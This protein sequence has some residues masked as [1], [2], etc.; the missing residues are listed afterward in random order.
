M[1]LPPGKKPLREIEQQ[2]DPASRIIDLT[3]LIDFALASLPRSGNEDRAQ[4]PSERIKRNAGLFTSL[5]DMMF[6]IGVRND[7]VHATNSNRKSPGQGEIKRAA[8]ILRRGLL[9][10]LPAI[11]P[12]VASAI[13]RGSHVDPE[14]EKKPKVEKP[15]GPRPATATPTRSGLD[16]TTLVL[17]VSCILALIVL[18]PLIKRALHGSESAAEPLRREARANR[19][20]FESLGKL[21]AFDTLFKEL[22]A[23]VNSGEHFW[24]EYE[25]RAAGERFRKAL[26]VVARLQDLERQRD[27]ATTIRFEAESAKNSA[28]AER[29][30]QFAPQTWQAGIEELGAATREYDS[31]SKGFGADR[32]AGAKGI[33]ERATNEARTARAARAAKML[34]EA[35]GAMSKRD[36]QGALRLLFEAARDGDPAAR[37]RFDSLA[38]SCPEFWTDLFDKTIHGEPRIEIADRLRTMLALAE[39]DCKSPA[40]LSPRPLLLEAYRDALRL[41]NPRAASDFLISIAR[42]QVRFDPSADVTATLEATAEAL[43]VVPKDADSV[44]RYARLAA[45]AESISDSTRSKDLM[46]SALEIV[47]SAKDLSSL[48][49]AIYLADL[50]RFDESLAKAL[51]LVHDPNLRDFGEIALSWLA[52]RAAEAGNTEI[53][54]KAKLAAFD[55]GLLG[56]TMR[57]GVALWQFAEAEIALS[58]IDDADELRKQITFESM[59]TA[60]DYALAAA[61]ARQDRASEAR[62]LFDGITHTDSPYGASAAAELAACRI[63]D[64]KESAFAVADWALSLHHDDLKASAIGGAAQEIA[65]SA[66]H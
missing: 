1:E 3:I 54:R 36:V 65:R 55:G 57:G 63:R 13:V 14:R 4:S 2:S 37:D 7:L 51:L 42:A 59:R 19:E 24:S 45:L 62:A 38:R 29:V 31:S 48:P 43:S 32:F 35:E 25:Y 56:S 26:D 20:H 27:A 66:T 30:A 6:A 46:R 16:R 28:I 12:T 58:R 18:P 50:K 23:E 60:A 44:L 22:D 33:F 53:H 41:P 8:K 9:E 15:R 21:P 11:D 47:A 34:E 10:A 17:I 64:P 52:W 5:P 61:R 40:P 49:E 39:R